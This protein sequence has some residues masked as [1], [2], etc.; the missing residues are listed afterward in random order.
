MWSVLCVCDGAVHRKTLRSAAD[1][2]VLQKQLDDVPSQAGQRGATSPNV[3]Q[4][5]VYGKGVSDWRLG[6]LGGV[7]QLKHHVIWQRLAESK[8]WQHL[9]IILSTQLQNIN[10]GLHLYWAF[11]HQKHFSLKSLFIHITLLLVI[12]QPESVDGK[13]RRKRGSQTVPNGTTDHHPTS[14]HVDTR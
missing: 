12:G 13:R 9:I 3:G 11:L 2:R 10:N 4:L 8:T 14:V 1:T 7:E 5:V 6:N